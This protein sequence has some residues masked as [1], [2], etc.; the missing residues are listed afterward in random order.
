MGGGPLNCGKIG[1]IEAFLRAITRNRPEEGVRGVGRAESVGYVVQ[2]VINDVEQVEVDRIGPHPPVGEGGDGQLYR[3][4][5]R[6]GIHRLVPGIFIGRPHVVR[7]YRH[8]T[9]RGQGDAAQ[10]AQHHITAIERPTVEQFHHGRQPG[11]VVQVAAGHLAEVERGEDL[12]DLLLIISPSTVWLFSTAK[13]LRNLA[14]WW[15]LCP[16]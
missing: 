4:G 11:P 14:G 7:I 10:L 13:T 8:G 9:E 6:S 1:G 16:V 2:L 3:T 5:G 12:G 15:V